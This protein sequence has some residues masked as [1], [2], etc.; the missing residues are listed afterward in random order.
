MNVLLVNASREQDAL[1]GALS[2]GLHRAFPGEIKEIDATRLGHERTIESED[3]RLAREL[4]VA[5]AVVMVLPFIREDQSLES[6]ENWIHRSMVDG[7]TV[8]AMPDR[9]EGLLDTKPVFLLKPSELEPDEDRGSPERSA[10]RGLASMGL[11]DIT[12]VDIDPEK[13][14]FGLGSHDDVNRN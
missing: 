4:L 7:I 6:I 13:L 8:M 11:D 2:S 3:V 12:V 14:P 5:D 10:R 1:G 9:M